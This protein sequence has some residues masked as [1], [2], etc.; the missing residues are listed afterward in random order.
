[1]ANYK[2]M[3]LRLLHSVTKTI[4]ELQKSLLEA[5]EIYI[6]EEET[7]IDFTKEREDKFEF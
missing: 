6:E 1:M 7:L 3:Y 4:D 5:E 2:K